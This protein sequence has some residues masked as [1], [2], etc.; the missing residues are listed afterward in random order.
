METFIELFNQITEAKDD[1]EYDEYIPSIA[2]E[3]ND[4]EKITLTTINNIAYRINT[5]KKAL[6]FVGTINYDDTSNDV[7]IGIN[8]S[9]PK[10]D[11]KRMGVIVNCTGKDIKHDE[12]FKLEIFITLKG[13]SIELYRNNSEPLTFDSNTKKEKFVSLLKQFAY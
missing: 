9:E 12:P 6:R 11:L 13:I 8:Y 5:T 2:V 10:L 1:E 7:D 4:G 3:C